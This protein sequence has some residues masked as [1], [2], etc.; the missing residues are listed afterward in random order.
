VA[1]N[2]NAVGAIQLFSTG[3]VLGA[4]TNQPVAV[5]TVNGPALG[6]GLHP[7]YAVVQ[8]TGGLKYRTETHWVRLTNGL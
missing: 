4:A 2:T 1:A 7:F 5:F 6:A 3:G 8:T